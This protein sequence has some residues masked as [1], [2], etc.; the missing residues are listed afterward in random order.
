LGAQAIFALARQPHFEVVGF[1]RRK[2]HVARAEQHGA[3][4]QFQALEDFF[5]ALRHPLVLVAAF[6]FWLLRRMKGVPKSHVYR[7]LRKGEVRV[8]GKRAKPEY[9][10]QAGDDVRLPPVRSSAEVGPSQSWFRSG[11]QVP[12]P[13]VQ[14]LMRGI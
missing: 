14:S 4:R 9:R 2:P 8:N 13:S 5:R 10:V 7:I 6:A 1:L 12:S 11:P 3:E